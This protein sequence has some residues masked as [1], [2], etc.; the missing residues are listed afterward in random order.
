MVPAPS[1]AGSLP[2]GDLSEYKFCVHTRSNVGASLLAMGPA[3]TLGFMSQ[4]QT[5]TKKK[6][7]TNPTPTNHTSDRRIAQSAR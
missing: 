1:R 6:L 3:Q 2:Q 5:E 4:A 7:R